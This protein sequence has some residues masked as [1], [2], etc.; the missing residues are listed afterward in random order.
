MVQTY[1]KIHEQFSTSHSSHTH[2][3]QYGDE[4]LMTFDT[5][6]VQ[7]QKD[8]DQVLSYDE[9]VH[10]VHSNVDRTSWT[11]PEYSANTPE[12]HPQTYAAMSVLESEGNLETYEYA[13]YA[14]CCSRKQRRGKG[15]GRCIFG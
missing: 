3:F 12:G 1:P 6:L 2:T 5:F 8:D 4:G 15:E 14:V 9:F 10:Q 7:Q 11:A 13:P